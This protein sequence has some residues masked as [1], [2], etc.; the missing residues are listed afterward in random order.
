MAKYTIVTPVYNKSHI[1]GDFLHRLLPKLGDN[2]LV[3]VD[4]N[5][6]D[7][8]KEIIEFYGKSYPE[9]NI[10]YILLPENLGFGR[11]N[12][13]G[14]TY[15]NGRTDITVFMSNDVMVEGDIDFDASN[16]L[17]GARLINFDTGW[18]K[19]K[20]LDEPIPYLEGW[21]VWARNEIWEILGLWDTRYFTD[22][23]DLDL[24][25]TARQKNICLARI[26]KPLIHL[27]GQTA[28]ILPEGRLKYTLE[29]Q[30]KFCEKWNLSL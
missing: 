7:N 14:F 28:T 17:Y 25:Y 29:S 22:Y 26:P 15:A 20:E 30:R 4:N 12:N 23:E 11:A 5:S 19:F 16:D 27:G 8:T 21:C 2:N 18:N 6:K 10:E 24:C 3:I 9:S 1:T 13:L